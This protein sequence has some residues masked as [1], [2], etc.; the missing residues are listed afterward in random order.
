MPK[1]VR[2]QILFLFIIAIFIF[3][4]TSLVLYVPAMHNENTIRVGI[5]HSQTGTMAISESPVVDATLLAIEEI[6]AQGG[7]LGKII[8]P[9]IKDGSSDASVFKSEAE[10]LIINDRVDVIFG[11]WTSASR[12][13][14]KPIVEKYNNLLFYPVQY[15]GL[16]YSQNIIYTGAA[17]NQQILPGFNWCFYNLGQSFFLVGSDYIFPRTANELIKDHAKKLGA[18]ILGERYQPLESREFADIVKEIKKN[19]PKVIINTINGSSN[20]YFFQEL[21]KAGITPDKIPVMSFSIAEG[22]LKILNAKNLAG[23][24]A[25]W[26]YFQSIKTPENLDFVKKFK[27]KYGQNRVVSDPLEAAYCAIKL[28]AQAVKKARTA[29]PVKIKKFIKGEGR[30]APEGIV[31]IDEHNNHTWKMVRI[32]K[33][34]SDGQ[35]QVVWDSEIAIRPIAYPASEKNWTGFLER[36]YQGWNNKWSAS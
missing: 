14:V 18:K 2:W 22:E 23:N 34:M 31:Y 10:N 11:C 3:F 9:I 30:N 36:L 24:Y 17:P 21:E 5:L 7:L 16:E 35:F 4:I 1:I 28:W 20:I 13:S 12:K 6:N 33:I 25:T 8:Q 26:S 15:E 32:G 29:N 27:N 19:Q